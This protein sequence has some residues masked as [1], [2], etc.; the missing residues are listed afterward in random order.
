MEKIYYDIQKTLLNKLFK[1]C[2]AYINQMLH[3]PLHVPLKEN[4]E[5][6]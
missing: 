4:T 1:I 2:I 5:L 6:R 3:V